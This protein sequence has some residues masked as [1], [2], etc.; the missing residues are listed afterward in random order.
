MI[1][2]RTVLGL[3]VGSAASSACSRAN[4]ESKLADEHIAETRQRVAKD[5][6][7]LAALPKVVA[8]GAAAR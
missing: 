2:S 3:V 4:F 5:R 1:L 7:T 6:A 8:A